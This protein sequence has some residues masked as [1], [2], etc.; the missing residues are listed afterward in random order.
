MCA[1]TQPFYATHFSQNNMSDGFFQRFLLSV[2]EEVCVQ[3]EQKRNMVKQKDNLIDMATMLN[4]IYQKCCENDTRLVLSPEAFKKYEDYHDEIADFRLSDLFEE[5]R[6]SVKSKSLGLLLRISGIISLLR[7][8]LSDQGNENNVEVSD[9][10][11]ALNI[12]NYSVSNAF[13]LLPTKSSKTCKKKGTEV[14]KPPLP[15]PENITLEHLV[16]YQKSTKQI[17]QQETITVI[18]KNK[19]YPIVN[20]VS[21]SNIATKFVKGLEKL[22]LGYI[23]PASKSFKRYHA[24]DESFSGSKR[25]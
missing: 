24:D 11:M 9:V 15:E 5:A 19:I 13:S 2:P 25:T 4:N 8:E 16:Q 14:R 21:G 6:L 20:K 23:S 1:F 22:G 3:M 10:D 18:S 17:L 7:T 12:V